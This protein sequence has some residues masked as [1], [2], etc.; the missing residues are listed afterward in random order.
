MSRFSTCVP[1]GAEGRGAGR[2]GRTARRS[3]SDDVHLAAAHGGE[4][5]LVGGRGDAGAEG[6]VHGKRDL[7]KRRLDEQGVAHHADVGA[8]AAELDGVDRGGAVLGGEPVREPGGAER[9]LLEDA[10]V[11]LGANGLEGGDEIPAERAANA[12]GNRKVAA[13]LGFGVVGAVGVEG[14]DDGAVEGCGALG[15]RIDDGLC[16]GAAERSV[17]EIMLHVDDD[18]VVAGHG[19]LLCGRKVLAVPTIV[20]ERV[21]SWTRFVAHSGS[22]A[23]L[24]SS[25]AARGKPLRVCPVVR[26]V[27]G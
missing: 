25:D 12:V 3:V 9:G 22:F 15:D 19:G 27:R 10:R 20:G 5:G 13:L 7:G 16:F 21:R 1:A 4:C 2:V 18:E 23:I 17:D 24:E 26:L 11:A 14:E 8:E 6:G